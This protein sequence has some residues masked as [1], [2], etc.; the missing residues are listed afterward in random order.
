MNFILNVAIYR[1]WQQE[2]KETA[3]ACV[4]TPQQMERGQAFAPPTVNRGPEE[5]WEWH[6]VQKEA[7]GSGGR[8]GESLL[9]AHG[10]ALSRKSF[11]H[12]LALLQF[13]GK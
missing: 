5:R 3:L 10:P 1:R 12:P 11:P 2:P 6:E 4:S 13:T 9:V 8:A 7:V